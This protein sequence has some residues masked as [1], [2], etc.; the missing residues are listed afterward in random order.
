MGGVVGALKAAYFNRDYRPILFPI[1]AGP[2]VILTDG[3]VLATVSM[4][5]IFFYTMY[6][7]YI[8]FLS[9]E[10]LSPARA[11]VVVLF[12]AFLP[13]VLRFISF[14]MSEIS[15]MA[16]SMAAL[17]HFK[18]SDFFKN[19]AHSSWA[20][21]FA[22]LS[23][24]VRPVE[25]ILSFALPIAALIIY[26][27]K[28][29][30]LGIKDVFIF[31]LTSALTGAILVSRIFYFGNKDRLALLLLIIVCSSLYFALVAKKNKLN[32]SFFFAFFFCNIIASAWWFPEMR[33]LYEW[34]LIPTGAPASFYH[35]QGQMN[36]WQ[37][38]PAFFK[39]VGA[40]PLVVVFM[41]TIAGFLATL[42]TKLWK[43][44]LILS[45]ISLLMIFPPIISLTLTPDI[46]YRRAFVGFSLLLVIHAVFALHAGL[47]FQWIRFFL[48]IL[49][50]AA[51]LF[52]VSLYLFDQNPPLRGT[53]VPYLQEALFIYNGVDPSAQ[54][55]E[56][57]RPLPLQ[58][59]R[60]AV[61]SLAMNQYLERPF[62]VSGLKVM[63]SRYGLNFK[64]SYPPPFS[65]IRQSY[66]A[67]HEN[68]DYVMVDVST[69]PPPG[70]AQLD[71]YERLTWDIGEKWRANKLDSIRL[72][73]VTEFKVNTLTATFLPIKEKRILILMVLSENGVRI[74]FT[75]NIALDQRGSKAYATQTESDSSA[76]FLIDGSE[77][78]AWGSKGLPE[79]TWFAV[80]FGQEKNPAWIN[81]ILFASPEGC[82]IRDITVVATND[83]PSETTKWV[84][85]KSRIGNSGDFKEKITI[86]N[87]PDRQSI[88]IE[89]DPDDL[90]GKQYKSIGLAC[91]S[92]TKG[93]LRNYHRGGGLGIYAREMQI[94]EKPLSEFQK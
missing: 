49:F 53:L 78:R 76:S 14:F 52:M 15:Q 12:M 63:N 94:T 30:I 35:D 42:K 92:K 59:A 38:V 46:A 29:K 22:G 19:K 65:D 25:T 86:P 41:L 89:I 27:L 51:R 44:Y 8:Y 5:L 64:V 10:Y 82:H 91:F 69:E 71:P 60:I 21:V 39:N 3:N 70:K 16:F 40:Q 62:D 58:G 67:L 24:A 57:L 1:L 43:E 31:A 83:V 50:V 4:T 54:T 93:Y 2:F 13:W 37:A 36:L 79:D 75:D 84:L 47:R 77:N 90:R 20:G 34:L 33:R 68:Y 66:Q 45:F 18:K 7:I 73:Y 11:V 32:A 88:Q 80:S 17:Y 56:K 9:R 28:K 74:P 85:L 55:L 23:F 61:F 48:L 72:S 81:L 26:S 87:L 6:L